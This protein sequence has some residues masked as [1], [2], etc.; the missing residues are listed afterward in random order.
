MPIMPERVLSEACSASVAFCLKCFEVRTAFKAQHSHEQVTTS[1]SF[2][3]PCYD[4]KC[5]ARQSHGKIMRGVRAE[6]IAW[7]QIAFFCSPAGKNCTYM[8]SKSWK[9]VERASVLAL[10]PPRFL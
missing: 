2:P 5:Q 9:D 4:A 7:S 10:V 1:R 8:H 3:F 6:A